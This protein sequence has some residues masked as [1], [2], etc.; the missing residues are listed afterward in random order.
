MNDGIPK[1]PFSVQYVTVDAF[2]NGIMARDRGTLMAK[3]DV[4]SAYRNV[5][6]HPQDRYLL[7]LKWRCR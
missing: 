3:F 4:V 5:A 2:I 7:G 1:S 6:V